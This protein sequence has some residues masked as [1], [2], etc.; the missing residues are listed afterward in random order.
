MKIAKNKSAE[1][2]KSREIGAENTTAQ[3]KRK[4]NKKSAEKLD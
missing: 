3:Q 4:N 2:E 1:P